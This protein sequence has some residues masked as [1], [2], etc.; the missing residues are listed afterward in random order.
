[1]ICGLP[2]ERSFASPRR[3]YLR[4][5][6][7]VGGLGRGSDS[8]TYS[9][10]VAGQRLSAETSG[11]ARR[12]H[13]PGQTMWLHALTVTETYTRL[14]EALPG[15][16]VTLTEWQ[17]E[18]A[19]WRR[20]QYSGV[21]TLKPDAAVTLAGPGYADLYFLE[22]DTGSQSANVIRQKLESYRRYAATGLEQRAQGG[23]FP[24][25]VFLTTKARRLE[26]LNQLVEERPADQ[27]R[28]FAVGIVADA[29][30]LLIGDLPL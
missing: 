1:M 18:P 15:S 12:P 6:R 9:L 7:R 23:V 4:L 28:L 20:F 8:W 29:G 2:D 3:K 26:R 27:A 5:E 21:S 14:I 16:G 19:S 22:I 30:S 24:R 17:G 11:R 13:L 10:G 25:V